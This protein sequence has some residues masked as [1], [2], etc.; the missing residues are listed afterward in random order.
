MPAM[1]VVAPLLLSLTILF[2]APLD[3]QGH[4]PD[5]GPARAVAAAMEAMRKGDWIGARVE[6]SKAGAVA[7]DLVEW[8]RLREGFGDFDEVLSFTE[9]RADWPGLPYL[10]E[11]SEKSLPLT[12]RAPDV[13]AFFADTEPQ[14]GQG[15]VA[16][17]RA[18]AEIGAEGDAQAHAVIAWLNMILTEEAETELLAMYPQV[19]A[20]QNRARL[21]MLLW[22][23]AEAAARRMVVR[24]GDP[25]LRALAEARLALRAEAPNVDA[26]IAAVPEALKDDAGLAYERFRWRMSKGRRED[27]VEMIIQRS[28]SDATLGQPERWA[29]ARRNLARAA[30]LEGEPAKAY[31]IA[32]PHHLVEGSGYAELEWLAGYLALRHLNA[33]EKALEHFQRFRVAVATPISLGRAGYW[34]GRALEALGRVDAARQAYSFGAEYQTSFYGLLAAEKAGLPLDPA[35]MGRESFPSFDRT[36]FRGSSVLQAALLLQAAGQRGLATRFMVHLAGSLDRDETGTLADLALALDEPYAALLIAKD[37]AQRG[38]TIERA[39][40]PVIDLGVRDLPVPRELALSIARRE[41]QF[42]PQVR[43][44]AGAAGLMQL[45]PG[46]ARDMARAL[47]LPFSEGRLFSDP[48]F[49]ATLGSAYLAKLIDQFGDNPVLVSAGY[50]AGP[51]RPLRWMEQNGDPRASGVDVVDWIEAIPFDETRNYVMRVAESIPIYR[52]RLTG[53][54]GSLN[55]SDELK[56][57]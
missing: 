49:N 3:A 35:L 45:M 6:A 44:P 4:A 7:R 11:Q 42:N 16:L 36:S 26:L 47:N 54:A 31:A 27:A 32:A 24:I 55:F 2:G 30:M 15:A 8:Q 38:W 46:T 17:V 37:A 43:S 34:E 48:G 18:F 20:P 51:R 33:P 5:S 53:R 57:R 1:H 28:G 13:I 22:R 56:G 40:Y 9:R 21:D 41:S 52:A 14:T 50:N 29:R 39:Y 23:G 19:L 12:G 10:K 25:G